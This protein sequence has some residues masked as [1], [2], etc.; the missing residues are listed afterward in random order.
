MKLLWTLLI[1]LGGSVTCRA[2][3]INGSFENESGPD[4]SGWQ[5]T[6]GAMSEKG[7]PDGGGDFCIKVFSGNTQGCWP[8]Y[9]YQKLPEIKNGQAFVLSGRAYALTSQ[10]VGLYFGK[11]SKGEITLFEGDTTSSISW[12]ELSIQSEFLLAAGDTA[13][14]V[15]WGGLTGGPV[16]GYGFFDRIEL[17]PA[18]GINDI[19]QETA[20]RIFPN[21]FSHRAIIQSE[22]YLNNATIIILNAF[23]QIA[24]QVPGISGHS[25]LLERDNLPAGL[26]LI[27]VIRRN[28]ILLSQK[29]IITD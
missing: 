15:L 1:L 17:Q 19:K 14:V 10:R 8:G 28:S 6:C 25:L 13:V 12:K 29:V 5:W 11:I 23:G 16:Q 21:P 27:R 4:L 20:I 7:A 24:R 2:Q 18:A 3:V 22:V 9:A 26:Y